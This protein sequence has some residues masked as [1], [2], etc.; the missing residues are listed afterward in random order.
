MSATRE[1]LGAS[2]RTPVRRSATVTA[3]VQSPSVAHVLALQRAAGNAAVSSL[4][5]RRVSAATFRAGLTQAFQEYGERI[6]PDF[7]SIHDRPGRLLAYNV[8]IGRGRHALP[9][10]DQVLKTK[11]GPGTVL[12]APYLVLGTIQEAGDMVRVTARMVVVETSEV[13]ASGLG[14]A[15][16]LD[17]PAVYAAALAA[18]RKLG[19]LARV[20]DT[21]PE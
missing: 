6:T 1:N 12:A 4:M 2:R 14:D 8:R 15:K 5:V 19:P 21:T 9:S 10:I 17:P 11:P 3:P 16:G 13:L 7:L 18:L 20:R